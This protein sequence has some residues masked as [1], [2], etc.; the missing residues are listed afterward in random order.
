MLMFMVMSAVAFETTEHIV[1]E[2]P[3][4][5]EE[6][7]RPAASL[8]HGLDLGEAQHQPGDEGEYAGDQQYHDE[9]QRVND[10]I[11]AQLHVV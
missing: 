4:D 9:G 8:S 1:Q 5:R 2:G 11:W 10:C 7:C 6:D 3:A